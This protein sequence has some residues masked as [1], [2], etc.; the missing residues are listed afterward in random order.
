MAGPGQVPPYRPAAE[1]A[2]VAGATLKVLRKNNNDGTEFRNF[3]E[4]ARQYSEDFS[5]WKSV[6]VS[7]ER[8]FNTYHYEEKK[9]Q[10]SKLIAYLG[11]IHHTPFVLREAR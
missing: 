4:G 10:P 2:L 3:P 7:K 9:E 6:N 11:P 8:Q 5:C 1:A